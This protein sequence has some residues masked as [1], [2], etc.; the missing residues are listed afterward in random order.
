[1]EWL[2]RLARWLRWRPNKSL[3]AVAKAACREEKWP[4]VEPAHVEG[5]DLHWVVMTG[6]DASNRHARI[7][8]KKATGKIVCKSYIRRRPQ[9]RS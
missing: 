8:I 6:P 7:V 4:W 1:M 9:S 2:R 5:N 3:L